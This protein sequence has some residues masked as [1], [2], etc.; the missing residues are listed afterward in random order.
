MGNTCVYQRQ[1]R[2]LSLFLIIEN[3]IRNIDNLKHNSVFVLGMS[4]VRMLYLDV[5]VFQLFKVILVNLRN[6]KLEYLR[7]YLLLGHFYDV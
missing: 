7:A 5:L 4:K 6:V 3:A 2:V 1:E